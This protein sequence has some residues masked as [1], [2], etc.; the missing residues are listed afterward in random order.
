MPI[1]Q[2]RPT[3]TEQRFSNTTHSKIV[4]VIHIFFGQQIDSS[5][6]TNSSNCNS[7]LTKHAFFHTTEPIFRFSKLLKT[8]LKRWASSQ[9][10]YRCMVENLPLNHISAQFASLF[11]FEQVLE[12]WTQS[13]NC[14]TFYLC[15]NTFSRWATQ[16]TFLYYTNATISHAQTILSKSRGIYE[17][18][19]L[20]K[21]ISLKSLNRSI[22]QCTK[23]RTMNICSAGKGQLPAYGLLVMK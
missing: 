5:Q 15:K 14:Y 21:Y 17:T 1:F 16:H 6:S 22:F 11:G 3:K 8:H 13:D 12:S 23:C 9:G 18:I 4:I 7:C 2:I 19:G 20:E 10:N